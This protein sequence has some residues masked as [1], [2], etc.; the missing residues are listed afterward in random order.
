[1]EQTQSTKKK[2][3]KMKKKKVDTSWFYTALATLRVMERV[4][5][6]DEFPPEFCKEAFLEANKQTIVEES[7]HPYVEMS[8]SSTNVLFS[9]L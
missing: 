1:M 9:V 6:G 3:R 2:K 7:P 5:K 8:F 4:S